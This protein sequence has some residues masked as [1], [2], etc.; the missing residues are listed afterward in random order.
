MGEKQTPGPLDRL[1][2]IFGDVHKL[3]SLA[4]L[5]PGSP[6]GD[7]LKEF[8]SK[9]PSLQKLGQILAR[10]PDLSADYRKSLQELENGIHTDDSRRAR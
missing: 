8:V 3:V 7:Y 6:R 9:V 1:S 10:N 2:G 5:P 4:Y